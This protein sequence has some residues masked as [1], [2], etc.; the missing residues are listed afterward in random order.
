MN[1]NATYKFFAGGREVTQ[2]WMQAEGIL[3][4][5]F[6]AR[7]FSRTSCS[8]PHK[9]Y[10]HDASI[11]C[12]K[13]EEII[14]FPTPCTPRWFRFLHPLLCNEESVVQKNFPENEKKVWVRAKKA[15]KTSFS[16]PPKG[17]RF[18]RT[19]DTRVTG[20]KAQRSMRKKRGKISPVFYFPPNLVPRVPSYPSLGARRGQ[21]GDNPGNEV[22]SPFLCAR[23]FIY[24][25]PQSLPFP[26]PARPEDPWARE[27]ED[28]LVLVLRHRRLR[29]QEALGTRMIF[30]E[31]ATTWYR[32]A[33]FTC[34]E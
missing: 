6:W 34:R 15:R 9:F 1:R 7:I 22:A 11:N 19:R 27:P 8:Y 28:L 16:A 18:S 25:C 5:N 12:A 31:R 21:V 17:P 24:S 23:I 14:L 4:K 33:S 30:I 3:L 29:E 2:R 32:A 10:T 13:Q 26:K 20:D